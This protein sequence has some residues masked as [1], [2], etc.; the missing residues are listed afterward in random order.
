[1]NTTSPENLTGP[2]AP[3]DGQSSLPTPRLLLLACVFGLCSSPFFLPSALKAAWMGLAFAYGLR[4]LSPWQEGTGW[5]LER[6]AIRR[7]LKV[8]SLV[9]TAAAVP[10]LVADLIL[11]QMEPAWIGKVLNMDAFGHLLIRPNPL[12]SALA[13]PVYAMGFYVAYAMK[14][15]QT[16]RNRFLRSPDMLVATA[17]LATLLRLGM[18]YYS[19]P[20][21]FPTAIG[22]QKIGVALFLL[23]LVVPMLSVVLAGPFVLAWTWAIGLGD[24]VL[25]EWRKGS[26]DQRG[27]PAPA[28]SQIGMVEGSLCAIAVA[29]LVILGNHM[30][31]EHLKTEGL[32]ESSKCSYKLNKIS[33][34]IGTKL[35]AGEATPANLPAA[36]AADPQSW[37]SLRGQLRSG[38]I[39]TSVWWNGP[40]V[41]PGVI[42][43]CPC[44][45]TPI[46]YLYLLRG[47][48]AASIAKPERV[49]VAFDPWPVHGRHRAPTYLVLLAGKDKTATSII[50]EWSEEELLKAL[51][52]MA[53]PAVLKGCTRRSEGEKR[54]Y[55]FTSGTAAWSL[56]LAGH[57]FQLQDGS[58]KDIS[59]E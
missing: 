14:F 43:N 29:G 45:E 36:V 37:R 23:A 9:G 33:E 13:T 48:P 58:G 4:W 25:K 55:E 27:W 17:Y 42:K 44:G 22:W 49:V 32:F 18:T 19:S 30:T 34:T 24:P 59:G 47:I 5:N 39:D 50:K 51:D 15:N 8:G 28:V 57:R 16:P 21:F 46:P 20:L 41:C 35:A 11:W 3:G 38:H 6:V 26:L 7:A 12:I 40:V 31:R 2:S 52:A 54:V 10:I 53:D 56:S 1:M